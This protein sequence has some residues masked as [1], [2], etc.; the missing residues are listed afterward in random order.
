VIEV[1]RRGVPGPAALFKRIQKMSE[2][3][4][5][6]DRI[7]AALAGLEGDTKPARKLLF[8]LAERSRAASGRLQDVQA[9][10]AASSAVAAKERSRADALAAEAAALRQRIEG[11]ELARRRAEE[12]MDRLQ[13]ELDRLKAKPS[14]SMEAI[15][16]GL[17][18]WQKGG[19]KFK[20]DEEDLKSWKEALRGIV[21]AKV[22][23]P[24]RVDVP[25]DMAEALR[26]VRGLTDLE[27]RSL[28]HLGFSELAL[29]Q[30]LCGDFRTRTFE[31]GP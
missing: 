5:L 15:T 27:V 25:G 16:R 2:T 14:F 9:E 31:V 22:T 20:S 19:R 10:M 26:I 6:R 4:D 1:A 8:D 17:R 21:G 30:S 11:A 29:I 12:G 28:C 18:E 3:S 13:G 7:D 23:G 24:G